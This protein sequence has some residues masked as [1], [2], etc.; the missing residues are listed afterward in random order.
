MIEPVKLSEWARA[1]GVSR[2][3]ATRWFHAGVLPVPAR[4]LVT[5]TILVDE[6]T[7]ADAGVAALVAQ[8]R[9]AIV[10]ESA[11]RADDLV[12]D[13]VEALTSFCPR[14]SRRRSA[15]RRAEAAVVATQDQAAS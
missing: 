8:G 9:R 10:V 11:E 15:K 3:S 1:N 2:Q 5:D 7:T 14:H 4:Q 6:A 12:Q 13:M